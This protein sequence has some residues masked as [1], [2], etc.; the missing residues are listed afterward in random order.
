MFSPAEIAEAAA[1]FLEFLED[2]EQTC[3][4]RRPVEATDSLGATTRS[5]PTVVADDVPCVVIV[6]DVE[7]DLQFQ[8]WADKDAIKL[9]VEILLPMDADVEVGDQVTTGGFTYT[10]RRTD[11][12]NTHQPLQH[13]Y[14][15]IYGRTG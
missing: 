8:Q 2:G 13:A 1:I 15:V 7:K 5:F 10:I 14:G 3:D 9:V 12:K 6:P 11:E 4:I